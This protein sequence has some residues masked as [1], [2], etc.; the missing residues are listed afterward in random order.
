[1]YG[2]STPPKPGQESS[3]YCAELQDREDRRKAEIQGVPKYFSTQECR[4]EIGTP[5][6]GQNYSSKKCGQTEKER[7]AGESTAHRRR[8]VG[9]TLRNL[10]PGEQLDGIQKK[11]I[12][13]REIPD[14][15]RIASGGE[16]RSATRAMWTTH[17]PLREKESGEEEEGGV[18]VIVERMTLGERSWENPNRTARR[19]K[20]SVSRR[21]LFLTLLYQDNLLEHQLT[22]KDEEHPIGSSPGITVILLNSDRESSNEESRWNHLL[23][24]PVT[25]RLVRQL[26]DAKT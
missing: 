21:V 3:K 19:S 22:R 23:G 6:G 9:G 25:R 26:K 13:S 2:G 7:C 12:P 10:D 16:D 24:L 8:E 15:I 1:M 5:L 18:L 17:P 20:A 4:K 14:F 11:M